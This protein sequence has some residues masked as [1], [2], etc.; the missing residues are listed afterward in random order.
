MFSL[1]SRLSLC[2]WFVTSSEDDFVPGMLAE[3][4]PFW[5]SHVLT[6]HPDRARL[7]G[8]VRDGVSLSEFVDDTAAGEFQGRP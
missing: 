1:V 2:Q 6:D 8:I 5:A 7:L 3:Q 4:W